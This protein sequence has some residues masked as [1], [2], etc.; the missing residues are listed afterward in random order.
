MY[1][2]EH[3]ERDHQSRREQGRGKRVRD[4]G[5]N[6]HSGAGHPGLLGE[7]ESCSSEQ[8]CDCE[9][10]FRLSGTAHGITVY[11]EHDRAVSEAG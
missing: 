9:H 8:D 11:T 5:G 4:T 7:D 2:P 10:A 1:D 6:V 3:L